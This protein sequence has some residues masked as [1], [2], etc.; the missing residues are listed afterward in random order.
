MTHHRDAAE[1]AMDRAFVEEL[2]VPWSRE[3][4]MTRELLVDS[5]LNGKA[6]F[7]CIDPWHTLNL[8]IGKSWVASGVILLQVLVPE[9]SADKRIDFIG[10]EYK[11]FC[12]RQKL[13]PVIRKIDISTF[14]GGGSNEATGAWS[15]AA[16]TSNWSLF[17]EEYCG[18]R[19]EI[20]RDERLRIFVPWFPFSVKD[21]SW[22]TPQCVLP[23]TLDSLDGYLFLSIVFQVPSI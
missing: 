7:H 1:V 19:P 17:L 14:G 13:D 15:K 16:V 6:R 18:S 21:F 8:G 4:P 23:A 5:S 12:R 3:C 10:R 22:I 9:S 2:P 11:A 20:Q